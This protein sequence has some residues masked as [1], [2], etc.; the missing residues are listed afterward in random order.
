MPLHYLDDV[1][2]GYRSSV[3]G[4]ELTAEEIVEFAGRWDPFPF[5][6]DE[7]AAKASVFG[8]LTAS[9]CHIFAICTRLWHD[10]PNRI[11]VLAMLGKDEMRFPNPA[12]PGDRL[13]YETECIE[14]R[15]SK[16]KPDRGVVTVRDRLVNQFGETVL[17]QK[18]SL[19]VPRRPD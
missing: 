16:S 1:E 18:V 2:V 5:H 7:R 6:T 3:G 14:K 13:T 11:E 15:V 10:D 4:Y 8:G 17:E 12:R 19:M 9:S